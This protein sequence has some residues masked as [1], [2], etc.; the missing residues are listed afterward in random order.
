M[1]TLQPGQRIH[2]RYQLHRRLSQNAGRQTWLAKD[3]LQAQPVVLKVLTLV[4]E[5]RWEDLKLFEREGKV[6]QHLNHPRIPKA[7]DAFA[8]EGDELCFGLVQT[9]IPGQ[10]LKQL[11]EAGHRFNSAQVKQIAQAVLET[12]I[13]LHELHPPVLHRDIKPSN[14]IWGQ[15]R[16]L[17]VIDFGAVQDRAAIEGRTFTVVGTYGYVPLEQYGGRAVPA[18]DLYSLGATLIHLLTGVAPMDLPQSA[19]GIQFRE[20]ISGDA[21]QFSLGGNRPFLNWVAKLAH[22]AVSQ[23]FAS[24]REALACLATGIPDAQNWEGYAL[25]QRPY[26]SRVQLQQSPKQIRIEVPPLEPG[27]IDALGRLLGVGV[28]VGLMG[29]VFLF[30]VILAE[31]VSLLAAIIYGV[32]IGLPLL[33]GL[34]LLLA[35]FDPMRSLSLC[36]DRQQFQVR[37]RLMGIPYWWRQ[38]SLGR[39]QQVRAGRESVWLQGSAGRVQLFQ[40]LC[41][42][43]EEVNWLAQEVDRWNR[44]NPERD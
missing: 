32:V 28:I 10:S 9:Y 8:L 42:S 41:L 20:L 22:P 14:L 37:S 18:S 31:Q 19:E 33:F 27:L 26:G 16:Q 23:R 4:G 36:L 34:K 39:L 21:Q 3:S 40:G 7:L 6:L 2:Q 12:L 38:Q 17:H 25:L 30:P 43:Q 35:K 5:T 29:F 44:A 15:D 24:A 13:Y 11:L 1:P